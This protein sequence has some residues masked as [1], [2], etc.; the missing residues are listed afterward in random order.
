MQAE[1]RTAETREEHGEHADRRR[2]RQADLRVSET[3]EEYLECVKK[4]RVRQAELRDAELPERREYWL[5]PHSP[6]SS[7]TS[8][9][10]R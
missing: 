10:T 9:Q 7:Q 5:T 8:E 6:R 2:L 4:K 1:I 3:R